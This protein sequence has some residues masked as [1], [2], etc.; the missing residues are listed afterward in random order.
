[1]GKEL[2]RQLFAFFVWY[3]QW[4]G[5]ARFEFHDVAGL[6]AF[7]GSI[8]AA[9]HPTLLDVVF[10][11]S[12]LPRVFCLM[13]AGIVSNLVLC[14]TARLAGYVD[15]HS[16]KQMVETC[17]ARLN[18]GNTLVIFP[19]G[20][21]T[22]ESEVNPFKMGF[23]LI[24]KLTGAPVQTVILRGNSPFLGKRWPFLKAPAAFPLRYSLRRGREFVIKAGQ[25]P[26]EFGKAVEDYFR[27][28]LNRDDGEPVP[29]AMNA[30]HSQLVVVPSYN[31]G[32]KLV[33]TVS[34][35]LGHWRPVWVVID[36]SDDGSDA[37]LADLSF[38]EDEL[39]ILRLPKN[40]GKGAAVLCGMEAAAA[41]GFSQA[42]VLDA[43]GQHPVDRIPLF[44]RMAAAN[45]DAMVLGV[46]QFG[47]DAPASRRNGR[48]VGNWW[49]NLETL[50]G[51]V[52]DS[53]FG[54]RV[55][56][57]KEVLSLLRNRGSGADMTSIL[58]PRP[59]VLGGRS[60]NKH[61]GPGALL[62]CCRR[63][64]FTLPLLAAQPVA[65][66]SPHLDGD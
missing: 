2:I 54:F 24:A 49:A 10:L 61:C 44:M 46:P 59:A 29:E 57:I 18:Q 62:K 45:P 58:S 39:R 40:A 52:Q 37:G 23:A 19:E 21:R 55:Y 65:D 33:E 32:R 43:D 64:R 13:K 56:P 35:A 26:R 48:K 41:A 5:L 7:R 11:V 36:G 42:L 22:V 30:S 20:T 6:R 25:D 53:L 47:P 8:I 63:R 12:R 51:G 3:L 1:M 16:A 38:E 50:W 27:T 17:A 66:P 9:N 4:T 60:A 28:C 15:N 31:S 34:A 14:G